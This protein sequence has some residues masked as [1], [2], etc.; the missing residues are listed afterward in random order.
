MRY[1]RYKRIDNAIKA[2]DSGGIWERWRYGRRLVCDDEMTTA[3]GYLLHG[4]LDWLVRRSKVS[5]REIQRRLQC[6]RAYP[7]ESQIRQILADFKTWDD[8][9]RANFPPV[10]ATEGERPYNPLETDEIVQQH[11]AQTQRIVEDEQ[12]DGGGLIPRDAFPDSTPLA[13]IDRWADQELELMA[14]G[15]GKAQ[16]R[17]FYV[18]GL[19]KA[20]GSGWRERNVT[21]GEAERAFHDSDD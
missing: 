7:Q 16:R 18:D 6:A 11:D 21:L 2:S 3:N 13:E 20:A 8:L 1:E 5:E 12:Y 15:M 19:I 17:R 10:S 9:H 14:R 4:K